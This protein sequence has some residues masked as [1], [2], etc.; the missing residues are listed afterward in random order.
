MEDI[1]KMKKPELLAKCTELGI[2][3]YSAKNKSELIELINKKKLE[4]NVI[5]NNTIKNNTIIEDDESILETTNKNQNGWINWTNKSTDINFKTKIKG[6][7]DGE[8][9]VAREL[10]TNVLG[11]NSDFDM[12]IIIKGVEH[13]C[14]VKKLDNYTF[15][16][17]VKGRNALRPIKTKLTD[18]LNSLIKISNIL[19]V[20]NILSDEEIRILKSFEEVSP[21]ELCVSNIQKLNK[22]LHILHAKRKQIISTLP[23]I[24]PFIQ[25]DNSIIEMNLLEY[26]NICLILKQDIPEEYNKFN[27]ILMLLNDISHEYIINPDKLYNSLNFLVSI[28]SELK[29]IFVDKKKGYCILDNITNIKFERITRGHP[30]FRLV[31]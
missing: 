23:N 8:E 10:D 30:R 11:Q 13:K 29:L 3:K 14:D 25:K 19:S 24:Q 5:E 31:V 21:D 17:G 9:K 6:V 15:N 1:L 2:T 4:N 18:L 28:F 7:G 12:K 26:Y 27:N 16:T 20:S 22:L